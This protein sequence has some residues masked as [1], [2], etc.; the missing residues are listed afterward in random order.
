MLGSCDLV[1][2][3]ATTDPAA[4]R[5]FYEDTLGLRLISEDSFALMF[6]ANGTPLRVATVEHAPRLP[7]TVLGWTVGDIT[8]TVHE[9]V[10]KGVAF[11][12]FEGMD[13]DDHF[14]WTV[15][16]GGAR[17]A[18]FKDPDANVLSLTQPPG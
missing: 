2:F 3:L 7:F 1:V 5:A 6:D 14:V 15:P 11:E 18:W 17:V 13:Q 8:V 9:L 12:R 4:A 10:A 16:G